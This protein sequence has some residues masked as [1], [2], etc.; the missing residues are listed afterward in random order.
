MNDSKDDCLTASELMDKLKI[1]ESKFYDL[2]RKY[3]DF[4]VFYL[5]ESPRYDY[6]AVVKFFKDVERV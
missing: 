3:K 6:D 4:P 1:K 5:G 2:K